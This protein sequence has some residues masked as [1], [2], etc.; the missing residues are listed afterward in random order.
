MLIRV[1]MA[2]FD[3]GLIIIFIENGKASFIVWLQ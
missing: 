2:F 3:I 1:I